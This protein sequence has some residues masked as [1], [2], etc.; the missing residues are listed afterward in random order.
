[1]AVF[2]TKTVTPG[3]QNQIWANS[4]SP[5]VIDCKGIDLKDNFFYAQD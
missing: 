5:P 3:I 4:A 1:M 2:Y